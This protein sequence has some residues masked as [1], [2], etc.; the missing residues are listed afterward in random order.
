MLDAGS[1]SDYG[2]YLRSLCVIFS[3]DDRQTPWDGQWQLLSY[4][5]QLS[6]HIPIPFQ[7]GMTVTLL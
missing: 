5:R 4:V 6:F 3:M 1:N 7:L 2:N